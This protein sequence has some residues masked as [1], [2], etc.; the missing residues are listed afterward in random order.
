MAAFG[1]T[2]IIEPATV[3]VP[4]VC[5]RVALFLKVLKLLLSVRS[6]FIVILMVVTV[7][8]VVLAAVPP[9]PEPITSEPQTRLPV[10][11][12]AQAVF[13]V[14]ELFSVTALVTVNMIAAPVIVKVL[15]A[16]VVKVKEF[17]AKAGVVIRVGALVVVGMI[18]LSPAFWPG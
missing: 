11:L 12:M 4:L 8:V 14:V 6:P 1:L 16:N 7:K 15:V 3:I 18:T 9:P 2:V 17:S 10:P 13:E 5:V